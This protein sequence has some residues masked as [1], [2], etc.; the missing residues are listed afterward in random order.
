MT[1]KITTETGRDMLQSVTPIYNNDELALAVFEANGRVMDEIRKVIKDLKHEMFP[2][3]ASWTLGYWESMLNIKTNKNLSDAE[4][5]QKIL[6][7]LNKYFPITRKRMEQIVNVH[8]QN[9][10]AKVIED[11]GEYSFTIQIPSENLII[12]AD[13]H[14]DVEEAKPAHLAYMISVLAD[15]LRAIIRAKQ[16]TFP[17]PYPVTG[18]F[19]TAPIGGVASKATMAAES[20]AYANSVPYPVTGTFYCTPEGGY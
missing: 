10:D 9:R 17:V 1:T 11:R 8:V 12:T 4:R 15:E 3:H 20:K 19:H 13:I 18:T 2:Q 7:E 14:R 16:Y 5:V 6:F